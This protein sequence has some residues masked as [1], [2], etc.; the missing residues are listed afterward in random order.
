MLR[1]FHVIKYEVVMIV[2]IYDAQASLYHVMKTKLGMKEC[3]RV[4]HPKLSIL[5]VININYIL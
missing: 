1:C 3:I 4:M 5:L 2:I